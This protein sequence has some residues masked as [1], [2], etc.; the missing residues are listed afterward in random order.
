MK[1]KKTKIGLLGCGAIG[2]EVAL[3][4]DN[5]LKNKAVLHGICDREEEKSHALKNKLKSKPV[6][7]DM[8]NLF[9]E[10]DLLIEAASIEA[11]NSAL[12]NALK[13]KKSLIVLSIGALLNNRN[14]LDLADKKNINIYA[15][16]GAICG[17][18][19]V[20]AL[21]LGNIK[22]IALKTSKP[23]QGLVGVNY[24]KQKNINL[25]N[26]KNEMLVFQGGV[27][28]AIK[29]F[30]QNIN[31]AATLSLAAGNK[32]VQ[33]QIY[34]DPKVKTN[35][36]QITI[37]AQETNISI[38][39]KN[40]PSKNNPKTSAMAILSTQNLLKKIFSSVKIGS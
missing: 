5:Q 17:I 38:T 22:T 2:E 29:Y 36:H 21:S 14:L 26:L 23:P 31:V 34:A 9:K 3:F 6:I 20:G 13:H 39:V 19:G 33:V 1:M 24:L 7:C 4:I 30:P 27:S 8:E 16:S 10:C 25:L 15:P 28:E 32:N 37:D 18:D 12:K 40:A 11:A 35:I